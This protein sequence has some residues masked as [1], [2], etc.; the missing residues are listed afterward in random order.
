MKRSAAVLLIVSV[1]LLAAGAASGQSGR[2]PRT[3]ITARQAGF[4][5]L[6]RSAKIITIALRRPSPDQ[7]QL[8]TETAKIA[9]LSNRMGS[10]FPKGSGSGK[11]V[12]T[13]ASAAIWSDAAKFQGQMQQF[14]AAA[15]R[16]ALAAR[17]SNLPALNTEW[18]AVATSCKACHDNFRSN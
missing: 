5:D 9:A 2:D 1:S 10:W 6:G 15:A 8:V 11:G 4:K 16:A 18:K 13:E 14:K 17:A 12:E 7:A 3:V